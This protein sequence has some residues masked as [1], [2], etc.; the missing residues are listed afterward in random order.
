MP[1]SSIKLVYDGKC[2]LCKAFVR[3][4]KSHDRYAEVDPIPYQDRT[5]LEGLGLSYQEAERQVYVVED[6]GKVGGAAAINRVFEALGGPWA[7]VAKVGKLRPVA[8]LE[9][10][11]YHWVSRN[12]RSIGKWI[13]LRPFRQHG[14]G[15]NERGEN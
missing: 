12:R 4:V 11:L 15:W 7:V 5:R 2:R 3:W 1:E 8:F 10:R 9:D 14:R 13:R 6:R